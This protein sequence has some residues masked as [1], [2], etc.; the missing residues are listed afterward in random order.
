MSESAIIVFLTKSESGIWTT[1]IEYIT[2]FSEQMMLK[3]SVFFLLH[4]HPADQMTY[5]A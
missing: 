3:R 2:H 5:K 4:L 1:F